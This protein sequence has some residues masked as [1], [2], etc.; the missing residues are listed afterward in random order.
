MS[1][2]DDDPSDVESAAEWGREVVRQ[3]EEQRRSTAQF[4]HAYSS[5]GSE[6]TVAYAEVLPTSDQRPSRPFGQHFPLYG[7]QQYLMPR[8]Q[9]LDW[10]PQS[11]AGYIAQQQ[12]QSSGQN[13]QYAPVTPATA[14]QTSLISQYSMSPCSPQLPFISEVWDRCV[15]ESSRDS[16]SGSLA[17]G[18]ATP[19][20]WQMQAM[21]PQQDAQ[22]SQGPLQQ[23]LGIW[24]SQEARLQMGS[25]A[26]IQNL[27]VGIGGCIRRGKS[28]LASHLREL[29]RHLAK[30]ENRVVVISNTLTSFPPKNVLP[31]LRG[32]T[33]AAGNPVPDPSGRKFMTAPCRL[34]LRQIMAK[35]NANYAGFLR[36]SGAEK[37]LWSEHFYC[38]NLEHQRAKQP[39]KYKDGSED[40]THWPAQLIIVE[41]FLMSAE[42]TED[43]PFADP[44]LAHGYKVQQVAYESLRNM[45][46]HSLC[47]HVP[48]AEARRRRFESPE[49]KHCSEGGSR[50]PHETWKTEEYFKEVAWPAYMGY[51]DK[52]LR[53]TEESLRFR[54]STFI[55]VDQALAGSDWIILGEACSR[56]NRTIRLE[57]W[58][59]Q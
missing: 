51:Y 37:K 31:R 25:V 47:L 34:E 50:L 40:A 7:M 55:D 14:Q 24:P 18:Q 30:G 16:I 21:V 54:A 41:G 11:F 20:T 28:T 23:G 44:P 56:I 49:Y 8:H 2:L 52:V 59:H 46:D 13:L 9:T 36:S 35:A 58:K 43:L 57:K 53:Q 29:F 42:Y 12:S 17:Q 6:P 15:Q 48:K 10:Q 32:E 3:E 1:S 45:M 38:L 39:Q 19:R 22:F 27:I 26:N 5:T 33:A 4:G